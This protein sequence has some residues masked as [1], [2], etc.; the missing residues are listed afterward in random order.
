MKGIVGE[1]SAEFFSAY[2]FFYKKRKKL[3]KE[4]IE[5][6]LKEYKG[7][8]KEDEDLINYCKKWVA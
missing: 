8:S 4:D 6:Y 1:E 5:N 7:G 3:T 2:E